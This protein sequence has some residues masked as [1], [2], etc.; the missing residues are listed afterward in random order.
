MREDEPKLRPDIYQ[1]LKQAGVLHDHRCRCG[2]A[3]HTP[4]QIGRDGCKRFMSTDVVFVWCDGW[5]FV[6]GAVITEYTL[7]FQRGFSQHPCGCWSQWGG[8]VNSLDA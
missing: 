7:R 1:M 4:H 8:S 2:T 5:Y 6:N 3:T